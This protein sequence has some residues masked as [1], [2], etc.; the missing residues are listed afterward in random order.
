MHALTP[1]SIV[2]EP[3]EVE[4]ITRAQVA[5]LLGKFPSEVELEPPRDIADIW[6]IDKANK[7]IENERL[8]K[9][10]RK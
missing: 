4:R 8:K 7:K 10:H 2:F 9:R 5:L 6:H 1:G 3:E